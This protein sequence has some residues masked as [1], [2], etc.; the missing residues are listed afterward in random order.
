MMNKEK[1]EL[2]ILSQNTCWNQVLYEMKSGKKT[3]HW[4]WYVF[5]QI[6]GLSL[7]ENGI[8]YS[9]SSLDD[10]KFYLNNEILKNRMIQILNIIKE[11]PENNIGTLMGGEPDDAKFASSMTLFELAAPEIT[12]FSEM[13]DKFDMERDQFTIDKIREK[14][15]SETKPDNLLLRFLKFLRD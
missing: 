5:P 15:Y 9:L 7:S 6:E 2:F 1:A 3:T 12:L 4:I 11:A 13:F 14:E 10:V 8:L